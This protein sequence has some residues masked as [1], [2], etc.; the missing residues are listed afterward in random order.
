M[1]SKTENA[2]AMDEDIYLKK[3]TMSSIWEIL[4]KCH[5]QTKPFCDKAPNKGETAQL[6][7]LIR[8]IEN[9]SAL[10]LAT[11][12]LSTIV[13]VIVTPTLYTSC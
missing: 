4:H 2:G 13:L 10:Q 9:T 8:I 11:I 1:L 3:G 6:L 12:S 5:A 7:R